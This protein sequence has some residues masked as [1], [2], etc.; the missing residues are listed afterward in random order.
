MKIFSIAA[1][2][3]M[4]AILSGCTREEA[5]E[6]ELK[7]EQEIKENIVTVTTTISLDENDATKA[8]AIDYGA[9][10]LTKTFAPGDQVALFYEKA[11]SDD[12]AKAVSNVLTD[13]DIFAEGKSATLTF[14]L[15]NPKEDGGVFYRYPAS[16]F[17]DYGAVNPERLLMQD[18]TL[19]GVAS[20]DASFYNGSMTGM[21]L[22]ASVKLN[23]MLSIVAFTLKDATGANNFTSTITNMTI[24]E[25][26]IGYTYNITGHDT[27]GHIYVIMQPIAS[28]T[29]NITATDGTKYYTKTL[30]GKTWAANNF[31][32]QGLKM[33]EA[34]LVKPIITWTSVLN[35]AAVEPDEYNRYN[36]SGP[37][38]GSSFDP[39]EF[40]ISGISKGYRF[41]MS[42][43]ATIHLNGLNAT[44]D[45]NP[46]F[47]CDV[48]GASL[49]IDISGTNSIAC[50]DWK[51]AIY[52]NGTVKLSGNGTLT[53]TFSTED[54]Y[55]YG[56]DA[57]ENYSLKNNS[58][59]SVLAAPGYTV[60]RS[61]C[62]SNG[63]NTYTCTYIVAPAPAPNPNH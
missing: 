62:T 46:F 29:V 51:H 18:G 33:E 60:S 63:D 26:E 15:V 32:Q 2:V 44:Y 21:T 7:P 14:K 47:N 56:I 19:S 52:V 36:V 42:N 16:L 23:N 8:L 57:R 48:K 25:N 3:A 49:T 41:H 55:S 17:N 4:G 54:T 50:K 24:S 53:L 38:N 34:A 11:G 35:D 61:D 43:S 22:P 59:A 37:S 13:S 45:S 10:T 30:T 58:N 5:A 31:Y 40:T 20:R 6:P 39:S 28:A 27:D 12:L 1:L 9:E